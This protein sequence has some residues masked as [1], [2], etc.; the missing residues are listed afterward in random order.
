MCAIKT[1][2]QTAA[3][4]LV[5]ANVT[6]TGIA[7]ESDVNNNGA[8]LFAAFCATLC[9]ATRALDG[10]KSR[11]FLRAI[12]F[13]TR[14]RHTI[15]WRNSD[16]IFKYEFDLGCRPDVL[17]CL[18]WKLVYGVHRP[19]WRNFFHLDG[20]SGRIH[21]QFDKYLRW[22]HHAV[23]S[24]KWH[25]NSANDMTD[26]REVNGHS[27]D[28]KWPKVYVICRGEWKWNE[29]SVRQLAASACKW[30]NNDLNAICNSMRWSNSRYTTF[31]LTLLVCLEVG[32]F[33]M[34]TQCL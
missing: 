9:Y 24:P 18:H 4:A 20:D 17:R 6:A 2:M 34:S 14:I 32:R 16:S 33:I 12:T 3:R 5:S 10:P 15:R 29:F 25:S 28:S 19:W 8:A 23:P 30:G 22:Q 21:V 31:G 13:P 1:E 27:F 7:C 11:H 26:R